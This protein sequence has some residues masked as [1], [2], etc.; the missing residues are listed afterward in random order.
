MEVAGWFLLWEFAPVLTMFFTRRSNKESSSAAA[1]VTKKCVF[2]VER[3]V[4]IPDHVFLSEEERCKMEQ[5]MPPCEH[6][7]FEASY[8][9]SHQLHYRKWLPTTGEPPRAV[10]IF[11]HGIQTHSGKADLL[12]TGRKI[13]VALQAEALLKEGMAMFAMDMYG[14]GYSEGMRFWIP[15]WENNKADLIN[16][17]KNIVKQQVDA[18]IPVFLMG[19]SYGSTLTLMAAKHFQD[20]PEDAPQTL[21]SIILTAPGIIGDVPPQP[22]LGIFIW[23]AKRYPKWRPFFMINPVSRERI[24]RDPEVLKIRSSPEFRARQLDGSGDPFI[25]GTAINLMYALETVRNDVLSD[26]RMPFLILHGT[27]DYAVP[28]AGSELLWETCATPESER[29]FVRKEGA[30]HDL[31]SDFVAEECMADVIEWINRRL[32]E[33]K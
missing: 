11:M 22:I 2:G 8:N 19:E 7:W 27:K 20:H 33:R 6:G 5:V 21:D 16:F 4:D 13:N 25:L 23:L 28:I 18:K 10:V 12:S 31:F 1:V 29:K 15:S 32:E 17:V 3:A 30:Y 26:L 9:S 14:H 24:W